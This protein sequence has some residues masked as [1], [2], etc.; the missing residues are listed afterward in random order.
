[1]NQS[2][3]NRNQNDGVNNYY[4]QPPATNMQDGRAFTNYMPS[5][6]VNNCI[7]K[8][9]NIN[10]DIVY[11]S[12]LTNNGYALHTESF[13][14]DMAQNSGIHNACIFNNNKTETTSEELNKQMI[15]WNM[16]S[17]REISGTNTC[18]KYKNYTL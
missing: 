9:L 10:D 6:M 7:M 4:K 17:T 2:Q 5:N 11:K 12:Y 3:C 1:M 8:S 18:I 16:I 14:R 15:Q 13:N